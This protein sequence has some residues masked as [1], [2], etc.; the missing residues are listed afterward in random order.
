MKAYRK[1]LLSVGVCPA[2][3]STPTPHTSSP[4]TISRARIPYT[5]KLTMPFRPLAALRVMIVTGVLLLPTVVP[6]AVQ[7]LADLKTVI[8]SAAA[9]IDAAPNNSSWGFFSPASP[10]GSL[11]SNHLSC[12]RIQILML[13]GDRRSDSQREH[14]NF[15]GEVHARCRQGTVQEQ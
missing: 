15:E 8:E 6:H 1:Y 7:D 12:M 2:S 3:W 13:K 14:H 10:A 9:T 5:S 11:V 4:A